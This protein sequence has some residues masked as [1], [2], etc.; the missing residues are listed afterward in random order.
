M[1][2][3]GIL[4]DNGPAS[5]RQGK[6]SQPAPQQPPS[7]PVQAPPGQQ[8][9]DYSQTTQASPS[10][11]MS[12]DFGSQRSSSLFGSPP[13]YHTPAPYAARPQPPTLQQVPPND[14]RSPSV[15]TG[16]GL[17]P[18]PYRQTPT[19]SI[20][21][22]G[23]GYPF[24]PTNQT[25]TSPVQLHQYPPQA[26][27]HRDSYPQPH[28]PA[29]V[30][31]SAGGPPYMQGQPMP[32]TPATPGGAHPYLH[33]RSQSTHS[34]PTPTSA[35][36]QGHYGVPF[37]QGSP[38]AT[39]HP[40]PGDH[41]QHQR[42]PSQPPTP[43][44]PP[45][46][47]ARQSS[48][49]YAQPPS[50][51]QQ[52][53]SSTGSY[54][55]QQSAQ[56]SPSQNTPPPPLPPGLPR[57]PSAQSIYEA[58]AATDLH[59]GSQSQSER[60]KSLS[61]S[62]K[63]RIPSLPSS[64]GRPSTS[65][66]DSE[67]FHPQPHQSVAMGVD[68]DSRARDRATTPAKRKL[69]DRDLKPDELEKREVRPAPFERVNGNHVPASASHAPASASAS[70]V[71]PKKKKR[72][73]Y[74]NAPVWAQQFQNGRKLN[75]ANYILHK[76]VH[77]HM[78]E[79]N[80]KQE[81]K[82]E[83]SRH[84]SPE[85]KRT[86]P[87]PPPPPPQNQPPAAAPEIPNMGR[88]LGPWEQAITGT[89]PM[90]E[91]VKEV[92]DFLYLNIVG[93]DRRG[94]IMA[95]G[96]EF[97]VEAKLGKLI[98]RNTNDRLALPV[99]T[100]CVV[101]HRETAFRSSM[102]EAQHMQ[103]NEFLNEAVQVTHHKNRANV[104]KPR[105]PVEYKHRREIDRF[106]ELPSHMRQQLPP[107]VE[108]LINPRHGLK[109][110]VTYDEKT[111]EVL[112]K[113]IKARVADLDIYMPKSL[114]DVRISINLEMAWDMS[115]EELERIG[116]GKKKDSP[117]RNKDR[118]SYQHGPYQIDLTQ[119]KSILAAGHQP[120]SKEEK[121]HELEIELS[122]ATLL[123]QARRLHEGQD[124]QFTELIEGFIDNA[125]ILS[126]KASEFKA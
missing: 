97:E 80:G 98:D 92:A 46:P 78:A 21:G 30:T 36:S 43:L 90:Q 76:P 49:N 77:D 4:N 119:V 114:L 11:P 5:S 105:L 108:S 94:E 100:E 51:Y 89:P 84:A 124:N 25:P 96:I 109:V 122:V 60:E 121:E 19:S 59:R 87:P 6:P 67:S 44:G 14:M 85:E 66:A 115:V 93:N 70:P 81:I 40:L 28:G 110:R 64:A 24:P 9:R 101:N 12:Q 116:G 125:K 53:L 2:L 71:I 38:A 37:V 82:T 48:A 113:I 8:F 95:H 10:R 23:G 42:Q 103:Y 68:P 1:D 83:R 26:V 73:R 54:I 61:V 55:H 22:P 16:P 62:P 91:I 88:P 112:A 45:M 74:P 79:L 126:R 69:D 65:R 47:G 107:Y 29:G 117:D 52:R 15:A 75:A 50:P 63:T 3:R 104:P 13:P 33:Q 27:Y 20:S 120:L 17:A 56:A 7:T 106:F 31:G 72:M 35:Q 111:K 18:S 58:Q 99:L 86:A 123:D 34:T 57:H 118:L 102:T 41:H 32:Q 39:T